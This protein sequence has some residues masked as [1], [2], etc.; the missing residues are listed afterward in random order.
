MSHEIEMQLIDLINLLKDVVS[1]LEH[2][3]KMNDLRHDFM[4]SQLQ[5]I[6]NAID[7]K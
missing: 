3:E 6:E 2:S 1:E 7:L 5:G 4:M